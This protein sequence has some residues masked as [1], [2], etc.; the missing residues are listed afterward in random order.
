M[1]SETLELVSLLCNKIQL[2]SVQLEITLCS[3]GCMVHAA[4]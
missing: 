1:V 3:G 4:W 2:G